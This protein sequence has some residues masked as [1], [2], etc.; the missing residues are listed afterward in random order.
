MQYWLIALKNRKNLIFQLFLFLLLQDSTLVTYNYNQVFF[1]IE[2]GQN[3]KIFF[4]SLIILFFIVLTVG[5]VY[6]FKKTNKLKTMNL[7]S[8]IKLIN[9]VFLVYL[10]GCLFLTIKSMSYGVSIFNPIVLSFGSIKIIRYFWPEKELT[11]AALKYITEH[12]DFYD[13]KIINKYLDIEDI[14]KKSNNNI[15]TVYKNIDKEFEETINSLDDTSLGF[16]N[17]PELEVVL[18]LGLAI[19]LCVV[20]KE[21]ISFILKNMIEQ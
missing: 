14:V 18:V 20:F 16:L 15:E 12:Y 4:Y 3:E 6:Y 13:R 9:I 2:C 21:G 11:K 8:W 19:I 10:A 1:K 17:N 7:L 5:L